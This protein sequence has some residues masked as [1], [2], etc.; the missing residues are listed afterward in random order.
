VVITVFA[1]ICIEAQFTVERAWLLGLSHIK[2]RTQFSRR[3]VLR[4]RLNQPSMSRLIDST[5]LQRIWEW[6]HVLPSAVDRCVHDMIQ[7]NV[8]STPSA[9]AICAWDNR[10]SY[11]ELSRMA[12]GL[13]RHLV[14]LGVR[15]ATFVPILFEKSAWTIV[16]MLAI[17]QTGAAFV[18]LEAS[19]PEDAVREIV[20]QTEATIMLASKDKKGVVTRVASKVAVVDAQTVHHFCK[21]SNDQP[22]P[23]SD[24]SRPMYVAFTS[25]S[26]GKPKG[27]IVTHRA[28]ASALFH[29]REA[30]KVTRFSRVYDFCSYSFD[31]SICN[32]FATLEAGGC[33]CV[34][35][36]EDRS[37]RLAESIASL[38]ANTI[39]LTPS[40]ARLLSPE[41]VPG[42]R[43]I[44]FGG[45]ALRIRDVEPWWNKVQIVSLYGPC[46]CTPNS[47]FVQNPTTPHDLT[48]MGNGAGLVTW[49]VDPEDHNVLLPIGEPGE[50]LLEGPLVGSGYLHNATQ[51]AASFIESPSWLLQGTTAHPGRQSRL[52]KTGDIVRQQRDGNLT[53]VGRKDSQ[54]KLRGQRIELGEIEH[55]IRADQR[56]DEVVVMKHTDGRGEDHLVGFVTLD[57]KSLPSDV[58]Q[59]GDME[60]RHEKEW[61]E[62]FENDYTSLNQISGAQLGRDFMGWTSMYDGSNIDEG[63]MNEWLDDTI[64]SIRNGQPFGNVLEVGTGS[65]MIL[66]NLIEGSES[67][68]GI[69]PSRRG[70]EF[71]RKAAQTIPE[72]LG[73]VYMIQG[74]AT[75]I[76]QVAL[77]GLPDK[78]IINSVAQYFPNQK[79]LARLIEDLLGLES[80]QSI[81]F[82]DIRSYALFQEFLAARALH[83]APEGSRSKKEIRRIMLD[84]ERA[85]S[86]LLIDPA[87]F[88]DLADRLPDR[89]RH[90]EILPKMMHATNEL[91]AFRYAAVIHPKHKIQEKSLQAVTEIPQDEWLDYSEKGLD[92]EGLRCLLESKVSQDVVAVLNI[93]HSK[94]AFE[95]AVL[96]LLDSY[97]DEDKEVELSDA[98]LGHARTM[99]S[100]EPSLD[101]IEL[102]KIAVHSGFQ[103]QLSWARQGLSTGLDAV[104]YHGPDQQ[105]QRRMFNFPTIHAVEMSRPFCN[106]PLQTPRSR[107]QNQPQHGK[108]QKQICSQILQSLRRTLPS[109]KVPQFLAPLATWP[110]TK[111]G[112]IDRRTLSAYASAEKRHSAPQKAPISHTNVASDIESQMRAIWSR[113][114]KLDIADIGPDD[115]FFEIGGSSIDIIKVVQAAKEEGLLLERVDILLHPRLGDIKE[116]VILI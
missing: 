77:M 94:S 43:T 84:A 98:W 81:F 48:T 29:Q 47:T 44:V 30:L 26:T 22:L 54:I 101:A 111:N 37:N 2:D 109:Y 11:E 100:K 112:K 64:A 110:L 32:I 96:Q 8:T 35:K 71:I 15:P 21:T 69:E 53:F 90:V 92:A 51:T 107:P 40:V 38:Q 17:M 1:D 67:Y 72:L 52:Y 88:T 80:V 75:D 93:P 56:V 58:P 34:P 42:I 18:L 113:I 87:F 78:V 19:L 106:T 108:Q 28:L 91:S 6:N 50:L 24:P 116:Y 60:I 105:Q 9:P 76:D 65:G 89:I 63:E 79:Y 23:P 61:E 102:H 70:V 4:Q 103:V 36:E 68:M 62:R 7:E 46:E 45:E 57:S 114:L 73:K 66:F 33:V 83:V 13:A 95:R 25:G 31:V 82:G 115:S 39:D 3:K 20:G 99:A 86:E 97:T 55:A 12:T 59:D 74:T 10:L 14:S 16:S 49:V 85:E 5:D 41:Q 104:F 27:A